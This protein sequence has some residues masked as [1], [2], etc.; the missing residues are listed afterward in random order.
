VI[1]DD[2][3]AKVLWAGLNL[4]AQN[5]PAG[6]A[7]E[8]IVG[9]VIEAWQAERPTQPKRLDRKTIDHVDLSSPSV[10]NLAKRYISRTLI[11]TL[12]AMVGVPTADVWA[13]SQATGLDHRQ[14]RGRV[15]LKRSPRLRVRSRLRLRPGSQSKHLLE[16]VNSRA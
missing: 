4:Q 12:C 2:V 16:I 7:G 3:W 6:S 11:P 10:R 8:P 14:P 13:T 5:L 15:L 1:A 9:Q